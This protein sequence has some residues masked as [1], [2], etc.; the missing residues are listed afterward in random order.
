M[1]YDVH[2]GVLWRGCRGTGACPYIVCEE[3]E[4][5]RLAEKNVVVLPHI[6]II[7]IIGSSAASIAHIFVEHAAA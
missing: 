6:I 4:G 1:P 5:L 2:W 7:I 3:L